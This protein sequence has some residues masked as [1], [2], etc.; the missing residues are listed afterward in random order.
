[1][2]TLIQRWYA[3]TPTFFKNLH[4]LGLFLFGLSVSLYG[5]PIVPAKYIIILGSVGATLAIISNFA[6]KDSALFANGID[7]KSVLAALPDLLNQVNTMKTDIKSIADGK[8]VTPD[9]IDNTAK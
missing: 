3:E 4:L 1:M 5:N 2:K 8:V 6:V 9:T 7:V